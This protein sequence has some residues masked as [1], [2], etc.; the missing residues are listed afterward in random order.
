MKLLEKMA[1]LLDI[2]E[3]LTIRNSEFYSN[4]ANHGAALCYGQQR[5]LKVYNSIFVNNTA[6]NQG[7]A[8]KAC[9]YNIDGVKFINNTAKGGAL[10][11][12]LELDFS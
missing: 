3:A 10:V 7:G 8:I 6:T 5:D 2:L 11:S 12:R 9:H 1:E 4:M